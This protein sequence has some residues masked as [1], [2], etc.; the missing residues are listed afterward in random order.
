MPKITPAL[1]EEITGLKGIPGS[2]NCDELGLSN[3]TYSNVLSF[4]DDARF[5]DQVV[6][7]QGIVAVFI[8][9]ELK[10]RVKGKT[11]ILCD[12]PRYFFYILMNELSQRSYVKVKSNIS[13]KAIIHP[14]A[15]V[16][17][18]NVEIGE[19]TIIQPNAT[20]LPDV[21]IGNHC[22]VQSGAVIGSSG[23]EYKRTKRGVLPVFHDGKVIIGNNVEIGA[24]TCIDKGFSFKH[25]VIKD[26]VK[27]DNLVH[28]AHCVTVC[29]RSF[30]VAASQV[31]GSV[32]IGN[33]S[34]VAPSSSI[35]NGLKIGKGA[36]IGIGAVVMKNVQDRETVSG[37]PARIVKTE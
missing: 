37:N 5:A 13:A 3:S 12:D 6:Q 29:E 28:I 4:L 11:A 35:S 31:A 27:I 16:A 19:G 18:Y 8:T 26:D 20:I 21:S 36:K 32:E 24:N 30:V 15:Y 7:N 14:T 22:F 10:D 23:F 2:I 33:D 9:E 17:E 1:I 25:T 34:W